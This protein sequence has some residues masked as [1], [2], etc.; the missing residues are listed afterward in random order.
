MGACYDSE[1][2]ELALPMLNT[3]S[4]TSLTALQRGVQALLQ[5]QAP[6]GSWEGE[7]GW[8]PMFTAQYVLMHYITQTPITPE[9]RTALLR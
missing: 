8:C 5:Q 3:Y 4:K 1:A 7:V 6:D 9:E 2:E